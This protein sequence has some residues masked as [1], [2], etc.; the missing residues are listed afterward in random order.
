[1]SVVNYWF[2]TAHEMALY[3]I[4]GGEKKYRVGTNRHP[5]WLRGNDSVCELLRRAW[6]SRGM[7]PRLLEDGETD[8][9]HPQD[10]GEA[11]RAVLMA[12]LLLPC[13]LG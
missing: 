6:R 8:W 4:I 13:P 2:G 11:W 9:L 7:S 3:Q 1:M 12:Q 10:G 5:N